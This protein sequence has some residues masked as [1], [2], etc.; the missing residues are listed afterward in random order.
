MFLQT[1]S[2]CKAYLEVEAETGAMTPMQGSKN[3]FLRYGRVK[4]VSTDSLAESNN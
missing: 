1:H 2:A 4:P 3:V